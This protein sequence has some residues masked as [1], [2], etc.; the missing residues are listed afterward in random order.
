MLLCFLA[1]F[2][3]L[4]AQQPEPQ[5]PI[6]PEISSDGEFSFILLPDPQSYNKFAANQPLFELQT[7]WVSQNVE[8][9]RIKAALITGDLVE[10]NNLQVYGAR[11]GKNNGDQ[12]SRGEWQAASRALSRMDGVVPYIACQGN[13]D[14]GF[15]ASETRYS[16]FGEYVTAERNPKLRNCLV[17]TCPNM[18]GVHT[19]ENAAYEFQTPAWGKLL[20]LSFEFAPRDEVLDWARNLLQSKKYKNHR[21][22]ILVH[23]FLS[24]KGER[25]VKEKYELQPRNWPSAV[26][27]KLVY[28]SKNIV[29]VLCGHSGRPP[30]IDRIASCKVEEID[31]RTNSAYR[32]DAAQ[33]GRMIPQMMFNSQNGDGHWDGNGGD[34]WLRILEFG[35]DGQTI[36]VRTFSPLFAISRLTARYAWREAS[37]D[38]FSFKVSK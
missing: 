27:E 20:I 32:E 3:V 10:H 34:C 7:A 12:T 38:C 8:R 6:Y 16:H 14:A 30:K 13:H 17:D 36:G 5:I 22:I 24:T 11:P 26:W 25:I 28:P 21:A 29:L 2:G 1:A 31:Y 9:L 4:S 18:Y 19:L 37:Y 23:S 33:D 35:K 15:M